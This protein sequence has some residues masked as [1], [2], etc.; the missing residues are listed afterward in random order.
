MEFEINDRLLFLTIHGSHAYGM[1]RPESDI[2]IKGLGVAPRNYYYSFFKNFE[3]YEGELSLRD[4]CKQRLE[5]T[6]GRSIKSN[7]KLDS[8][9]Y[10]ITKFFKLASQCNP[11]IIEVLFVD[12]ESILYSHKIMEMIINNRDLFLSM[13]ANFRFRG[14]AFSQLKRIKRHRRWLLNPIESNPTREDYGLPQRTVMPADQLQAAESLIQ[15]KVDEWIFEQEDM[16]PELLSLV[17]KRTIKSFKEAFTGL[18][19]NNITDEYEDLNKAKLSR[20][21][22][23][24]LGY[25]DNFLDLLDSERRYK[26]PKTEYKQY[27]SWQKNRNPVRAEM[28]AESGFDRKHASHLVRLMKMAKEILSE[29][30]VIVKRPDAE[31]LLGIRNGSM[32]YEEVVKWAEFQ[33]GAIQEIY[34]SGSSPLP[35]KPDLNKIDKLHKEVLEAVFK[36]FD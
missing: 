34:D 23:K 9:I 19:I 36:E 32:S 25:S 20:G 6:I 3:Q 5:A 31:E 13:K 30:K 27:K 8:V 26:A 35:K 29:G 22:G 24:L 14:Y 1:A 28:E 15:K 21:A 7:E 16:T 33:D 10:N 12:D 17:R 18:G 2:D 11:N 4:E